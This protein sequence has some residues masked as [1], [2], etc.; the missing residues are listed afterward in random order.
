MSEKDSRIK[1]VKLL[2]LYKQHYLDK[3]EE[4]LRCQY[5]CWGYFDGMDITDVKKAKSKLFIKRSKS[6][7][8]DVW[9]Q[10]ARQ[11]QQQ[12]GIASEQNI[13]IFRCAE[14]EN[15]TREEIFWKKETRKAFLTV[16]FVQ[17]VK[18][19]EKN[20]VRNRI[21][22][23]ADEK[24]QILTY[25]TFDNA[26]IIIFLQGNSF[27][28]ITEKLYAIDNDDDVVY[29][30][31][32]CGV[33]E[34]T[35]E[36]MKKS[37]N[38]IPRDMED[39]V[40]SNDDVKELIV[41]IAG[42]VG[43]FE[44]KLKYL[45]EQANRTIRLKNYEK[46]TLAYMT[47]QGNYIFSLKDTD[48]YSVLSL[49]VPEGILTHKNGVFGEGLYNMKTQILM[50]EKQVS[51]LVP[52]KPEKF[53]SSK[54]EGW[55]WCREKI[56]EYRKYMNEA[57]N[58]ADEGIYSYYQSIIHTLN[59]LVQFERFNLSENIF[60]IISPALELFDQQLRKTDSN[61]KGIVEN[62]QR[63]KIM[64]T[65][66]EFFDAVN[67]IVYHAIHMDQIFLMVPG[68]S[69]TSF[70]IPTKL[71][72]FYLW[73]LDTISDVLNDSEY[74]YRFYLTPVMESKPCTYLAEFGLSVGDRLICVKVS[75]RSLYMP[76]ALLVILTH[77]MAHYVGDNIRKREERLKCIVR[78]LGYFIAEAVIPYW[79][80]EEKREQKEFAGYMMKKKLEIV[81][82]VIKELMYGIREKWGET[83]SAQLFHVSQIEKVL[84]DECARILA[85]ENHKLENIIKEIP[86]GIERFNGDFDVK[87]EL[88]EEF[89]KVMEVC[90]RKRII[91]LASGVFDRIV[92]ALLKEYQEIFADASAIA[93]AQFSYEDY[94]DAFNISEGCRVEEEKI[95]QKDRNRR[96]VISELYFGKK[97]ETQS[98]TKPGRDIE[99]YW[100][101]LDVTTEN[102]KKYLE[103]CQKDM[104]GQISAKR[105]ETEQIRK[106]R[107]MFSNQQ[108][109]CKDIYGFIERKAQV[110]AGKVKKNLKKADE[111]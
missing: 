35:L 24:V 10:T 34:K 41:N 36:N 2:T 23:S 42:N 54:D 102:M 50:K 43:K 47:G 73:Y 87:V 74:Q 7:V 19:V 39:R 25:F 107:Q 85:D 110:Y 67:S 30:H 58:K 3:Y 96:S 60:Y 95:S 59:A 63:E 111:E 57:W 108:Y 98:P 104:E 45:L 52:E 21:E 103:I 80:V 56:K 44:G 38:H 33:L 70:S 4:L 32:I 62:S 46:S 51:K 93:I 101:Y 90:S 94:T 61:F 49:L 22:E 89:E 71:S 69:G 37:K 76:R 40:V 18:G 77:E 86:E 28:A 13:E 1:G 84:R 8:S 92:A 64:N 106:A 20:A 29:S 99:K 81:K 100:P 26:D 75:Q 105:V 12:Q 5:S 27:A 65:M 82:L 83:Q 79:I 16:C 9:Y 88:L 78:T 17:L 14:K 55:S 6:A 48:M 31:P 97:Y 11:I 66:L 15:D 72:M 53:L 91:C 68:V 109:V